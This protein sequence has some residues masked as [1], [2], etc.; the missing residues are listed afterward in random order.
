MTGKPSDTTRL[1]LTNDSTTGRIT[2]DMEAFF[3]FS[4]WMAEELEDLI[5][6]HRPKTISK[7]NELRRRDQ[8]SKTK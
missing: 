7:S 5:H 4:F 3:E 6:R 1:V 8:R 2:V